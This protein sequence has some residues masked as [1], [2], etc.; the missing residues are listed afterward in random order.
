LRRGVLLGAGATAALAVLSFG[1]WFAYP[2]VRLLPIFW[3]VTTTVLSA[4]AEQAL[5]PNSAFKECANC[6]EMVVVP[7]GSFMMGSNEFDREKP[8]HGVTIRQP[9]AVGKFE[10]TFDEWDACVAHRGCTRE[11][12]DR[13]WGRGR[14]PVM[15]VSWDDAKQYVAWIAKL[16][17]KPYRLLT[18]A[19]WEYAARAGTTTTYSW[20]NDIGKGNANCDPCGSQWDNKQTAPVGSFK[21]YGFGL[22]DMHGN[23][24][25][26]CEDV[27]HENYGGAPIDGTPW[28]QGG[29][30]TRRVVRGGSWLRSP[31]VLRAASRIRYPTD[32]RNDNL[33]FRLARTLNP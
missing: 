26:W 16:T 19:E 29:E 20:G 1:V 28:L 17:G 5:K 4:Q 25:E 24:W 14:R 33:G 3:G 30:A 9:F 6:P 7:A 2:L 11:P 23:V 21:P 27:W 8:P 12:D 18:E 10:V 15:N 32:H 22:Y 31:Q 13:S